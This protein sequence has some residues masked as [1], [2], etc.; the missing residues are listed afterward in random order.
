MR[1]DRL[2]HP[3]QCGGTHGGHPKTE[4]CKPRIGQGLHGRECRKDQARCRQRRRDLHQLSLSHAAHQFL[5]GQ[6]TNPHRKAK[7]C[8]P[9]RPL[10]RIGVKAALQMQ[11]RPM[12]CGLLCGECDQHDQPGKRDHQ[13]RQ[14]HRC[15]IGAFIRVFCGHLVAHAQRQQRRHT[16]DPNETPDRRHTGLPDEARDQRRQRICQREQPVIEVHQ[17]PARTGLQTAKTC[18]HHHIQQP[19]R[20][21][22]QEHRPRKCHPTAR[23]PRQQKRRRQQQGTDSHRRSAEL[24]IYLWGQPH[25]TDGPRSP[26]QQC[27][28]K[29]RIAQP[30]VSF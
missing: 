18:V 27:Q 20:P 3:R 29:L 28:T 4:N 8:R 21:R 25:C 12:L 24:A 10:C 15:S 19:A 11:G 16:Q 17:G 14:W 23:K 7:D 9:Q 1:W 6:T 26:D 22:G 30:G 2:A 5:P 13:P